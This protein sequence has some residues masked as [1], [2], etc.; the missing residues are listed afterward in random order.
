MFAEFR[1]QYFPAELGAG[2][3]AQPVDA[4][5]FWPVAQRLGTEVQI[6]FAELGLYEMPAERRQRSQ[7]LRAVAEGSHREHV[8]FYAA[9]GEPVGWSYGHMLDAATFFMSWSAVVPAFRRRG[10]YTAY[11]QALL[12]YLE[13]LGYERV[14]SK[15][16][17][18]NRPVLIAKLKAGFHIAGLTLDE[19][20]GAQVTLA[21]FFAGDRRE[22]FARAFS[23]PR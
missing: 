22:G 21:Y 5:T 10:L 4:A 2:V 11:L 15:H 14:T 23:L 17:V 6:P 20:F 19:R 3:K 13:A 7:W 16:L 12:P 9:E 1:D 8:L 18:T